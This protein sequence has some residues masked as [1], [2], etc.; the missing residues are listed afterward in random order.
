MPTDEEFEKVVA[1]VAAKLRNNWN[2]LQTFL[3]IPLYLQVEIDQ[4]PTIRLKILRSLQ[5]WRSLNY[6]QASRSKLAECIR[7]TDPSLHAIAD[8]LKNGE[9]L[10]Y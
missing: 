8:K 1:E 6:G 2:T 9:L 5:D 4:Q 10:V 7:R 3:R